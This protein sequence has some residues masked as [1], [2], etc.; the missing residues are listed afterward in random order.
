[1]RIGNP[2]SSAE[3]EQ[4][5]ATTG[6]NAFFSTAWARV[7]ETTYGFVPRYFAAGRGTERKFLLPLMEVNSWLTGRRGVSLPFTDHC[8]T[9][10]GAENFPE[11]LFEEVLREGR[12]RHWKYFESRGPAPV[13]DAAPALTFF[14]HTL[15]LTPET[16]SLFA[17]LD[18]ATRRAIRKAEKCGVTVESSTS[19]EAVREYYRL[20]CT[21]RKH[22]GLPPQPLAFFLNIHR[23]ILSQNMGM[24]VSARFRNRVI[25]SA[26]FFHP[27]P[28][29]IYKFGASDP[30]HLEL[31]GNNLVMWEAIRWCAGQGRK[32]LD[33]GR[34]S[35]ANEGLRRFKLG[36][37]SHEREIRYYRYDFRQERFV[38]GRDESTGW[39][40]RVF[41]ALPVPLSRFIGA[42]LYRHTA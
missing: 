3:W 13:K 1:M 14:G 6:A 23:H 36:W 30:A 17:R 40:T 41:R 27:G 10:S 7:L 19:I 29:A 20:H 25:A 39:H 5:V 26:V 9:S 2:N 11:H 16:D 15:A 42:R 24:I 37:G 35:V 28:N 21:T 33:F 31:R 38:S 32:I 34:T 8:E 12:D 4:S 22:H 18:S